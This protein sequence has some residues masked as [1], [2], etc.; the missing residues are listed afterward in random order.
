MDASSG[1][2]ITAWETLSAPDGH[3]ECLRAAAKLG[4]YALP[5]GK[6]RGGTHALSLATGLGVLAGFWRHCL[7]R[8]EHVRQDVL[9]G[10]I[11]RPNSL[12]LG[13]GGRLRIA[14]TLLAE[15]LLHEEEGLVGLARQV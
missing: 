7:R 11:W 12:C 15:L 14:L 10:L 9:C 5:I 4:Q 6:F 2:F 13:A 8:F 3:S 1:G